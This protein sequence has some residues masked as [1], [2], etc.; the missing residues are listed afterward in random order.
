L[1]ETVTSGE[2][3]TMRS[4]SGPPALAS[5]LRI[6]P[7]AAWVDCSRP[8]GGTMAAPRRHVPRPARF[9][10]AMR[11]RSDQLARRLRAIA[12]QP[13]PGLPLLPF[14]DAHLLAQRR[15]L[16]RV[17]QAGMIV[18]VA[19]E[20]QPVALDRVDDE[21][22]RHVVLRRV[23][24]LGEAG[25]IVAGEVGHQR[26]ERVVVAASSSGLVSGASLSSRSRQAAPP[27]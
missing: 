20:G 10:R 21:E 22:G 16:A 9:S 4:A 8:V 23:E 27:R 1:V 13:R 7:N 3:V 11:L 19:G 12:A 25:E 6:L 5:S 24:R 15:H 18:L 26:R 2:V 14:R 17:H